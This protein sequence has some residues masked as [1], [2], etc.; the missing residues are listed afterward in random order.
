[1]MVE[2]FITNKLGQTRAAVFIIVIS[3]IKIFSLAKNYPE[4]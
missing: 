4:Y 1:M 2:P 3:P